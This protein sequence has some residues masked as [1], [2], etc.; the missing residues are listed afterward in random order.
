ME[1]AVL[2]NLGGFLWHLPIALHD[3]GAANKQFTYLVSGQ[4]FACFDI[5]DTSLCGRQGDADSANAAF[6]LERVGMGAGRSFGQTIP[7]DEVT[8]REFFKSFLHFDR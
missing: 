1:P 5:N 3:L 6:S 7:F 2:E 4:C 8:F